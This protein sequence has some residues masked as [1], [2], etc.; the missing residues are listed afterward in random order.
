MPLPGAPPEDGRRGRTVGTA[1][2]I[3][4]EPMLGVSAVVLGAGTLASIYLI[5]T[6]PGAG[7]RSVLTAAALFVAVCSCIVSLFLLERFREG[8]P[9]ALFS[10]I[11]ALAIGWFLVSL[12][13]WIADR[14]WWAVGI[15]VWA[16]VMMLAALRLQWAGRKTT[17]TT[18]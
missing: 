3:D 10:V 12:P 16:T 4:I 5:F 14:S 6:A 8:R 17:R 18:T 15:G 2:R 13:L 11:Q 1:P 7:L 9:R